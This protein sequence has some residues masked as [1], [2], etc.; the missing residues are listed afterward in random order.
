[1]TKAK[2]VGGV[3]THTHTHTHTGNFRKIEEGRNTFIKDK[4]KTDYK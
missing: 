3:H 2:T 1:M 4:K